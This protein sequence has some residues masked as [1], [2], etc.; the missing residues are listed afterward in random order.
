MAGRKLALRNPLSTRSWQ[1]VLE[2]LLGYLTSRRS[3]TRIAFR[4][5][6]NF[7]PQ[8]DESAPVER[9]ADIPVRL[10]GAG[11][12]CAQDAGE[13]PHEA[14]T[15]KLDSTKTRIDLGWKPRLGLDESLR[16]TVNWYKAYQQGRDA[17][18]VAQSQV[19]AFL[20]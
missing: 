14:A 4:Q 11:A 18:A 2:P 15:L 9:V 19:R 3:F 6:W 1:H 13:H 5:G 10:W 7:G 16:L 8:T 17:G 20:S 12:G